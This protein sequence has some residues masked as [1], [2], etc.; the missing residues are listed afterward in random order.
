MKKCTFISI[1]VLITTIQTR[2]QVAKFGITAGITIASANGKS[3]DS[4]GK[5]T[6]KLGFTAGVL[7]DISAGKKFSFQPAV[8]FVQKG[9][10]QSDNS[11]GTNVKVK[12]TLNYI[13]V[14]LNFVFNSESPNSTFFVGAGP[15]FAMGVSGKATII[16]D[17]EKVSVGLHFGST[18]E[19]VMKRFD[20]GANILAGIRFKS[21]AFISA[22]YNRGLSNNSTTS[23]ATVHNNYVGL[24]L[25]FL[26]NSRKIM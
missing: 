13:E 11:S 2:A 22:N 1:V 25:G 10:S 20:V 4:Q 18:P 21:G 16:D 23:D 8:N 12:A 17:G 9:F 15:S 26:L 24:K 14:P 6:S 7:A 5:S 19:D 3:D